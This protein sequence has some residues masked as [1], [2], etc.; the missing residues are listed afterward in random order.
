MGTTFSIYLPVID[1]IAQEET[2][3]MEEPIRQGGGETLLVVD[4][5]PFLRDLAKD[6]LSKNGY[7][8]LTAGSG[9]DGLSIYADH[10]SAIA[11]IILDLIMPGMGGKQCM[12][13]ILKLDPAAKILISSGYTMDDP[14]RDATLSKARGYIPKPYNFREMLRTIREVIMQ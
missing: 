10:K 3:T 14:R 7:T 13:E 12:A 9:E 8:I 2:V 6:M 4:D 5:E 1:A 11:V